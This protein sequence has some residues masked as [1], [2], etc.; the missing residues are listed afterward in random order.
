MNR[1]DLDKNTA[2]IASMFDQVAERYDLMNGI[3]S[4]GQH[5][6]WRRHTVKSVEA[7]AGQRILDIAAGTG[8]SSEPFADAGADVVAADLSQGMLEVGR[9]RRPDIT[10]V[11]ADVTKLPFADEEFDAVTMS[12]GLRNVADYPQALRELYRV[13]KPGG[14]I[15]VLEFS[16]PTFEPFRR[17]YKNYIMKAIPPVARTLSSNPESY[18]YLAESIMTWPS[19]D[20]LAQSF[21][22]AGWHDVQ[23][24]NLTGGIVAIHRGF[25]PSSLTK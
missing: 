16:T 20:E 25:K 9:R 15:V 4:G 14:R 3:L 11:Q 10:F 8:T 21:S 18:E 17:I 5:L 1:A 12:Y 7:I 24:R 23:Y 13:T 2:D 6:R 22:E 19:Q